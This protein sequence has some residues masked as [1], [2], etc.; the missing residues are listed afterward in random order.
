MSAGSPPSGALFPP[1]AGPSIAGD[2]PPPLG[3]SWVQR[4]SLHQELGVG[5]GPAVRGPLPARH[6]NQV[7][8]PS[9]PE[10]PRLGVWGPLALGQAA[11][12][13]PVLR[14]FPWSLWTP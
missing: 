10:L 13:L 4:S 8:P 5:G 11:Q 2:L 9:L 1:G 3:E 14:P 12:N 7:V 6:G